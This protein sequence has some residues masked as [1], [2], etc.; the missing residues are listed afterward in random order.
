MY[1]NPR[2]PGLTGRQTPTHGERYY[3]IGKRRVSVSLSVRSATPTDRLWSRR[4]PT[5]IKQTDNSW[6]SSTSLGHR[7]GHAVGLSYNA[8]SSPESADYGIESTPSTE[9]RKPAR[10]Q[11]FMPIPPALQCMQL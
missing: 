4:Q 6:P 2:I 1:R 10:E 8:L 5:H 7:P 9:F 3:R 11:Q